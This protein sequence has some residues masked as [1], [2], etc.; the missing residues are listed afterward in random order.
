MYVCMY[1]CVCAR[2]WC[3][4][5]VVWVAVRGHGVVN[6]KRGLDEVL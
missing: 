6:K 5:V 3:M 1:L 2:W 4:V